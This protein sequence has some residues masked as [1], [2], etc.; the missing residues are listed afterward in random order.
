LGSTASRILCSSSRILS[1]AS[2][3][4]IHTPIKKGEVLLDF[5]DFCGLGVL[6]YSL[7]SVC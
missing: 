2:G 1:S 5:F 6:C 7:D 4:N 3:D